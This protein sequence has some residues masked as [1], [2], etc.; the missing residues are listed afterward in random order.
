MG[1][2][3][4]ALPMKKAMKAAMKAPMKKA[5]KA[6]KVSTIAKGKRGKAAVFAGRKAKTSGGLTK[7][8][9]VKS[10]TGKVVGKARSALAKKRFAGSA[11]AKWAAATKRA[12]KELK[13]TGFVPIGGKTAQGKALLA[14]VRS[15][16]A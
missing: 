2:A 3:A 1:T 4:M 16:L 13:I 7:S 14:K 11:L 10:K 8:S 5:M 12:R 6:M 15:F 9:L